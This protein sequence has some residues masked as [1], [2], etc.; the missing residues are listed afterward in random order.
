MVVPAPRPF[1]NPQPR[2]HFFDPATGS[3]VGMMVPAASPPPVESN[4]FPASL[5][6][7]SMSPLYHTPFAMATSAPVSNSSSIPMSMVASTMP[8]PSVTSIPTST[9]TIPSMAPT[10]V[11]TAYIHTTGPRPYMVHSQSQP[12][13]GSGYMTQTTTVPVPT[14]GMSPSIHVTH[15]TISYLENQAIQLARNMAVGLSAPGC[16][17]PAKHGFS[18]HSMSSAQQMQHQ[19]LQL[20][21]QFQHQP[22]QSMQSMQSLQ[23]MQAMQSMQPMTVPLQSQ[24]PIQ[25]L[26][27]SYS[28][29]HGLSQISSEAFMPTSEMK[30]RNAHT[31]LPSPPLSPTLESEMAVVTAP[32]IQNKPKSRN[33]QRAVSGQPIRVRPASPLGMSGNGGGLMMMKGLETVMSRR[34]REIHTENM[35]MARH[36]LDEHRL[37]KSSRRFGPIGMGGIG[38]GNE[39]GQEEEEDV[40]LALVQKRLSSDMLRSAI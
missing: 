35:I 7:A 5:L 15:Q 8:T 12:V 19:Q 10:I 14:Y 21:H 1:Y 3:P 34:Q 26:P 38:G 40:P 37:L 9:M 23:A 36:S 11:P 16:E 24:L 32:M 29:H 17:S 20:Q 13:M 6:A 27:H 2:M 31:G 33:H 39:E 18:I 25:A 28:Q 30:L 4:N 22:M